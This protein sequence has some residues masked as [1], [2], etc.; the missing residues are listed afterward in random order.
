MSPSIRPK[1]SKNSHDPHVPVTAVVPPCTGQSRCG[2]QSPQPHLLAALQSDGHRPHPDTGLSAQE[3]QDSH[4]HGGRPDAGHRQP[5][6]G[7]Q[8]EAAGG[9]GGRAATA[10]RG[11]A[12]A[13]QLPLSPGGAAGREPAPGVF[14]AAWQI[15]GQA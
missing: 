5:A 1:G 3:E 13:G 14:P 4:R 15:D 10:D 9:Q 12:A 6:G 7:L 2:G 8:G 11:D